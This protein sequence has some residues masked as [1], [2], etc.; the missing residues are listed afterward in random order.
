MWVGV[1]DPGL[2]L[3]TIRVDFKLWLPHTLSFSGS[4]KV[5]GWI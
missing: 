1:I 4:S 3:E 5:R 2:T